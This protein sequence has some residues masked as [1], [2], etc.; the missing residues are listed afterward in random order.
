MVMAVCLLLP[1][2]QQ[3]V[4][5]VVPLLLVR[6]RMQAARQQQGVWQACLALLK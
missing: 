6:V 5:I 1:A 4:G 2:M 3:Q